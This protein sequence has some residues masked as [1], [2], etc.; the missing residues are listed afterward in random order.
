MDIGREWGTSNPTST[1][2]GTLSEAIICVIGVDACSHSD[3]LPGLGNSS[4]KGISL[5]KEVKL[6]EFIGQF[7]GEGDD[8]Q[9]KRGEV[10]KYC[11]LFYLE[12]LTKNI[13]CT[14]LYICSEKTGKANRTHTEILHGL[15]QMAR[16]KRFV[17]AMLCTDGDSEYY[18]EQRT[19]FQ[20]VQQTRPGFEELDNCAFLG[21]W[22]I[23]GETPFGSDMLHLLKHAR[24]RLLSPNVSMSTRHPEV[25]NI[26]KM[27]DVLKLPQCAVE[28][29]D[30]L[31]TTD[32]LHL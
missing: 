13:P 2:T 24:T 27:I 14:P 10:L 4:E 26:T 18:S 17:V 15:A 3:Y 20:M 28:Q 16:E 22:I 19:S 9:E 6:E 1:N 25:V 5:A 30:G 23:S 12:P 32:H 11:F 31:S 7:G 8:D 21:R 29:D